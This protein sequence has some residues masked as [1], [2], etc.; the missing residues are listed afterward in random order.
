[1]L[2]MLDLVHGLVWLHTTYK[3]PKKWFL[4]RQWVPT[5]NR[6]GPNTLAVSVS[7]FLK[8]SHNEN[9]KFSSFLFSEITANVQKLSVSMISRTGPPVLTRR[10][11][12]P[13]TSKGNRRKVGPARTENR[14]NAPSLLSL[15]RV[16]N[17]DEPI[18]PSDSWSCCQ[19][20]ETFQ[21]LWMWRM[22]KFGPWGLTWERNHTSAQRK[23]QRKKRA[24]KA[25]GNPHRRSDSPAALVANL[26]VSRHILVMGR[27]DLTAL[28]VSEVFA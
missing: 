19:W 24:D 12:N 11:Q 10:T 5:G 3:H 28:N 17:D 6:T 9:Q 18:E 20:G 21:F 27:N 8:L 13:Y 4:Y 7:T 14:S 2:Q 25:H 23:V 16:K 15:W 22:C 26:W 1:M